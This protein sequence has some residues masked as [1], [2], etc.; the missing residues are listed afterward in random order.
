MA[1]IKLYLT[2]EG[3]R[4]VLREGDAIVARRLGYYRLVRAHPGYRLEWVPSGDPRLDPAAQ[5]Y[6]SHGRPQPVKEGPPTPPTTGVISP[7]ISFGSTGA[8]LQWPP[9]PEANIQGYHIEVSHVT[10]A[11]YPEAQGVDF[12]AR[13]FL[14][15]TG[16]PLPPTQLTFNHMWVWENQRVRYRVYTVLQDG[17][18]SLRAELTGT[19]TP[20]TTTPRTTQ[21]VIDGMN[22]VAGQVTV[23]E[24]YHFRTGERVTCIS[25]ATKNPVKIRNCTFETSADGIRSNGGA[26]V[27]IENC[28]FKGKVP[29]TKNYASGFAFR[30][31]YLA[32]F[33]ARNNLLIDISGWSLGQWRGPSASNGGRPTQ[34]HANIYRNVQA[35]RSDGAGGVLA[36]DTIV[37]AHKEGSTRGLSD[38]SRTNGFTLPVGWD[39]AQVLQTGAGNNKADGL[40]PAFF[41]GMDFAANFCLQEPGKGLMEDAFSI[42]TSGG[43]SWTSPYLVRLWCCWGNYG[44]GINENGQRWQL[45]MPWRMG[46]QKQPPDAYVQGATQP[47][48]EFTQPYQSM[49]GGLMSDGPTPANGTDITQVPGWVK[50]QDA[51]LIGPGT[52][53][54]GQHYHDQQIDRGKVVYTGY[55]RLGV[56]PI[57]GDP[58]AK[59][60][61]D[62]YDGSTTMVNNG[63]TENVWA[64][65]GI[66]NSTQIRPFDPNTE[67]N[68]IRMT[69][70]DPALTTNNTGINRLATADEERDAYLEFL[71]ACTAAGFK[72]GPQFPAPAVVY[73]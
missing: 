52:T 36:D 20:F 65:R 63:V 69:Y 23:F 14:R 26:Q 72:L 40:R 45:G 39:F 56:I 4:K 71:A 13:S 7:R 31:D 51:W 48:G 42:Y 43:E 44:N 47:S 46:S 38:P 53:L 15:V 1:H 6:N 68:G 3:R 30:G 10:A 21:L 37:S 25:I 67:P 5:T 2:R 58:R 24:G 8:K 19:Q 18:L 32:S 41:G 50:V 62:S 9:A 60:Y 16:Q 54:G 27:E 28:V 55:D 59:L 70:C 64:R 11:D 73:D 66:S 22:T 12:P 49:T 17:S 34:I 33:A 29:A 61:H 57:S 35:K